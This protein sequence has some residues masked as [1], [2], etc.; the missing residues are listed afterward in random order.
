MI[1]NALKS[2]YVKYLAQADIRI[3]GD[4][5]WDI[6][7]LDE[8]LYQRFFSQGSI[9]FGEAYMD[10]WWDCEQLDEMFRRLLSLQESKSVGFHLTHGLLKLKSMLFNLQTISRAFHVG[11]KHYNIGNDLFVNMLD[12]YMNYSCGYW[13]DADNLNAAQQ[14]KMN[15]IAKKLKLE[16][17]MKVLDIGCGWGGIAKFIAQRYQVSITGVTISSEQA[18]FARDF[19][20]DLPV[21]II[22]NDYRTL[23]GHYDR[24]YSIG[25]FEHIGRK[26]YSTYMKKVTNLIGPDGLFLLQTIGTNSS[27]HHTDP[28]IEKYIF[29]N[30]MLPSCAQISAATEKLMVMENWDNLNTDYAKT[31]LAWHQN[32]SV[33]W[34]KLKH[35]YSSRF[36]RM[37]R[38]YLLC[39]AGSFLA[40]SNQLWQVTLSPNGV[41]NGYRSPI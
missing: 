2:R 24:A 3:N 11:E 17:G 30:S 41:A 39:C 23:S 9:G 7:V 40:R 38:Y 27:I 32:F 1:K 22:L 37:W 13:R 5:P 25:M 28:W 34:D 35:N 14:A 12:E 6:Q 36:Y 26:N 4:N 15:L 29:P 21:D 10:K 8:R 20:K 19:C 18:K 33:A 16:P 31:L